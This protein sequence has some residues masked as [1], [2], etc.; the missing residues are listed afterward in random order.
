MVARYGKIGR[1]LSLCTRGE[2]DLRGDPESK[3]NSMSSELTLDRDTAELPGL[4]PILWQL[5]EM[6]ARR[7]KKVG[8]AGKGVTLK[9]K[10][11]DFSIVTRSR[12]PPAR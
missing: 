4:R 12:R 2:D 9:L 11:A 7:M 5:A 8:I 6:V 3:A 10:T 1:R